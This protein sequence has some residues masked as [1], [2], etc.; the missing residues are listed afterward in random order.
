MYKDIPLHTL[1]CIMEEQ[2][3]MDMQ[4]I[5]QNVRERI[6]AYYEGVYWD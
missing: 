1:F 4:G 2:I 3:Q 6:E 5:D